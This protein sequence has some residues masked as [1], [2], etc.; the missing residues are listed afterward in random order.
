MLIAITIGY[1]YLYF[2]NLNIAML[3]IHLNFIVFII[4]FIM[5]IILLIT[6]YQLNKQMRFITKF[7]SLVSLIKFKVIIKAII[8]YYVKKD[9]SKVKNNQFMVIAKFKVMINLNY[10]IIKSFRITVKLVFEFLL[11][12]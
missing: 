4:D 7:N 10:F 3:D 11:E 2:R 12:V 5:V 1:Q 6:F 9:L 8:G